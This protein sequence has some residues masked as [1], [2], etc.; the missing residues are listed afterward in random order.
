MDLRHKT[1]VKGVCW[2]SISNRRRVFLVVTLYLVV[3]W[4]C[5]QMY[6]YDVRHPR[7]MCAGL[8]YPDLEIID[9]W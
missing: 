3:Y 4:I 8:V 6:G 5:L 1:N 7:L 9:S 2:A